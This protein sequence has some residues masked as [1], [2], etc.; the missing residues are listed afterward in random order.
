[1]HPVADRL[2]DHFSSGVDACR[3]ANSDKNDAATVHVSDLL[4]GGLVLCLELQAAHGCS[5]VG[6]EK[7]DKDHFRD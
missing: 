7:R 1:M 6:G 4:L 2:A 3:S 5:T